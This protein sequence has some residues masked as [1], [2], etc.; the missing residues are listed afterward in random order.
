MQALIANKPNKHPSSRIS[1]SMG[2]TEY[3]R[4]G[5]GKKE[6]KAYDRENMYLYTHKTQMTT[7]KTDVSVCSSF[8]SNIK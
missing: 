5:Q 2:I 7:E 4:K 1:K 8:N 3:L 6:R